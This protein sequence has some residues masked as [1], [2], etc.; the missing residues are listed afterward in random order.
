MTTTVLLAG[1]TGM[2]GERIAHH[3]LDQADVDVRLL[4]RAASQDESH[5]ARLH[6][7][8]WSCAGGHR[9]HR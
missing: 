2:L 1:A 6:R 3:L 9:R 5:Q 8:R 4:M 7:T